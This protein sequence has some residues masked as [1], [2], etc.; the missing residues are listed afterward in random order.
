MNQLAVHLI[1]GTMLGLA[2]AAH[3]GEKPHADVVLSGGP[4]GGSA[5]AGTPFVLTCNYNSTYPGI[6]Y[7]KMINTTS[8]EILT[9]TI[10]FYHNEVIMGGYYYESKWFSKFSRILILFQIFSCI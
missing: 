8:Q 5:R 10:E 1:L 9:P 2:L 4:Q 7:N 3:T 6:G